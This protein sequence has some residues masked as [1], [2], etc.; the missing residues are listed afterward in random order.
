MFLSESLITHTDDTN[1]QYGS[2][3]LYSKAIA[4]YTADPSQLL[5][6]IIVDLMGEIQRL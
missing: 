6:D 5:Y 2:E 4:S 1:T 3:R